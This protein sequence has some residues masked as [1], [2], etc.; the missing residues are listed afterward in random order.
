MTKRVEG[1]RTLYGRWTGKQTDAK[2]MVAK[3]RGTHMV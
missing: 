1:G 3:P 2:W